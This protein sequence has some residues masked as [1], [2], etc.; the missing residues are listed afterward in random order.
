MAFMLPAD[1]IL[2]FQ[3]TGEEH[4]KTLEFLCRLE[5]DLKRPI[6]R[7]EWRPPPNRGDPPRLAGFEEVSHAELSRKGEPLHE[8]LE[9]F[10][11]FRAQKETPEPPIAPW[12]G[13]R[14]C[15]A[16]LKIKT[17]HR[18]AQS[19][20]WEVYT[21]Y[22]G[23]RFDE[24]DRVRKQRASARRNVDIQFPLYDAGITKPDVISWWRAKPYDLE[25]P[26]HLGNCKACFMKDERDL[27]TAL[28]D[29]ETGAERWLAIERDY[30]PMRRGR[31]SYAQVLAEAPARMQIRE[32]ITRGDCIVARPA[33]LDERRR[34][35]IVI[36]ELKPKSEPWSCA[37]D[38]ADALA[39]EDEDVA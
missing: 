18:Y 7:L 38:G 33:G 34:K 28:L 26:E 22:V 35:L 15:T 6:V 30:A 27:A 1:T 2:T 32:S 36:Q 5:D 39:M 13:R 14:V 37:C 25:I 19:L 11:A 20:G 23:L 9:M 31:T 8:L 12:A 3:N 21:D 29:P 17:K 4:E 10:A 24:P 16:H